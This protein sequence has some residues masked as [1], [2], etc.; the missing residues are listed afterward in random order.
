[1]EPAICWDK[2]PGSRQ[3]FRNYNL[4]SFYNALPWTFVKLKRQDVA[5][6]CK[7]LSDT[8]DT[9]KE[10]VTLIKYSPKRENMLGG[11]KDNLEG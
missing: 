8:M 3:G 7:V 1:M 4:K 10:I 2:S 5:R 6:S 9:S 11:I